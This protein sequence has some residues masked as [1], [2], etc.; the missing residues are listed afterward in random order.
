M[1]KNHE[2]NNKMDYCLIFR[3]IERFV[4]REANRNYDNNK[5]IYLTGSNILNYKSSK[6]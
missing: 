4:F 5:S 1:F 3:T 2:I 6:Y